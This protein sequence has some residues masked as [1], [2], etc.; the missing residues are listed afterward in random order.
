MHM[1]RYNSEVQYVQGRLHVSAD[2]LLRTP[3]GRPYTE[4]SDIF[5]EVDAFADMSRNAI[6]AHAVK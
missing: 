6:P 1:M 4:D 2:A 3:V 5:H